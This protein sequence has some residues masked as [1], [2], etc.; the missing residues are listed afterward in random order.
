MEGYGQGDENKLYVKDWKN[1]GIS[2]HFW[3]LRN[4]TFPEGIL[5]RLEAQIEGNESFVVW[6]LKSAWPCVSGMKIIESLCRWKRQRESITGHAFGEISICTEQ[7]QWYP[8]HLCFPAGSQHIPLELSS[9]FLLQ[10]KSLGEDEDLAGQK[11]TLWIF[12][13]YRGSDFHPP[14]N[15]FK[16]FSHLL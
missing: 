11:S 14:P 12:F 15:M 10:T 8:G 7:Q 3:A 13:S 4:C 6:G 1:Y 2:A 16:Y 9:N 5:T